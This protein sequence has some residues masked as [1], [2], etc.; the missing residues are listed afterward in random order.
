MMIKRNMSDCTRIFL[1]TSILIDL[2]N[3]S[4]KNEK[5]RFVRSLL[6][7][8]NETPQVKGKQRMF[9]ISAITIGEMV[10]FA[11]KSSEEVLMDLLK[12]LQAQN[13]EIVQYSDDVAL[14]QNILFKEYLSKKKLNQLIEKLM[15][16]PGNY[17][18]AREYISRDFMIISSAHKINADVIITSDKRTFHPIATDL[19]IFCV[20][21]EKSN[22]QTSISGEK[23]Y[24]FI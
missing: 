18:L 10:K 11:S 3:T 2:F 17:V 5:T 9:Y 6:N 1:D 20:V 16:F 8:L 7:S 23:V 4:E 12:V 24:E 22:F 15:L 19:N 14:H 13:L 21:A